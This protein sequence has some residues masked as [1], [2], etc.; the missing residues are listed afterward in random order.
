MLNVSSHIQALNAVPARP[1]IVA[2]FL[3]MSV[4]GFMFC[5]IN[6]D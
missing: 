1:R 2:I 5:P 3:E 4:D 6:A